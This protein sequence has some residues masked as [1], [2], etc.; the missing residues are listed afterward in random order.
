MQMVEWSWSKQDFST[1]VDEREEY[2]SPPIYCIWSTHVRIH[3]ETLKIVSG[4]DSQNPD[5]MTAVWFLMAVMLG[6][7]ILKM[8]VSGS[9]WP[10][11]ISFVCYMDT[12]MPTWE[13]HNMTNSRNYIGNRSVMSTHGLCDSALHFKCPH[14]LVSFTWQIL[15]KT[16]IYRWLQDNYG[17]GL[18]TL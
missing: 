7:H 2:S 9:L 6:L 5:R 3:I 14:Y 4:L 8:S 10:T 17:G 16:M 1:R 15:H 18:V 11:H 13:W 12:D